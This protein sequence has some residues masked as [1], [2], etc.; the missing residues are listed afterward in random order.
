L[1][2][3]NLGVKELADEHRRRAAELNSSADDGR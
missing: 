2:Y 3:E 1:A